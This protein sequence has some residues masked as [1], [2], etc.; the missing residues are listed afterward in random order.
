MARHP[1]DWARGLR[2]LRHNLP[3][4]VLIIGV[5]AATAGMVLVLLGL[6]GVIGPEGL[7]W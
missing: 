4:A 5:A 7:R 3:A 2:Y 6:A 1:S